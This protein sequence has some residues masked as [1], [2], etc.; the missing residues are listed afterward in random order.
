MPAERRRRMQC[1]GATLKILSRSAW[2]YTLHMR[3]VPISS[4]GQ[5]SI[6]ANVRRRWKTNRVLVEDRGESL[7]V[8]PVPED[9][10]GAAIGSLAG[11]GPSSDEIRAQEREADARTERRRAVP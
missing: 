6:P 1:V 4:G 10:I 2:A 8:R 3:T 7:V 9:P 5:I 11:P